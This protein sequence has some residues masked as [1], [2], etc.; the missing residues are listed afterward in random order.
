MAVFKPLNIERDFYNMS[1]SSE[2]SAEITL[3]GDVVEERPWD[4]WNDKPVE[5]NFIALNDFLSDF[6]KFS[7]CKKINFRINSYGGDCVT[8]FVIHN[9]I[10]DLI[11]DGAEVSCVIDG[12]AMSAASIIMAA[13]D[14][15]KVNPAS[16]VMIHKCWS[17]IWGGY[18][19]DD[20]RSMAEQNDAY[21]KAI[22]SAYAR[23]TGLSETVIMH[24][25]GDTTYMT[26]KEAV[27]KGFADELIEDAEPLNLAASADGKSIYVRGK[28]MHLAPGMFAP[29]IIPTIDSEPKDS[30]IDK[31]TNKEPEDTGRTEGGTSPM[32]MDELRTQY[33]D[34]V[35][36]VEADASAGHENAISAAVN[37]E[38]DRIKK[39]DEVASLFSDD[40]VNEAKFGENACTAEQLAYR[41][42]LKARE[43]GNAFLAQVK[44][45][46][47]ESNTEE[48]G[49]AAPTEN[50]PEE[51]MTDEEKQA[52]AE[53]YMAQLLGKKED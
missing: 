36:Q 28:Q 30:A 42:A 8:A 24:M 47:S 5:G 21:D 3:Y 39:I 27:E 10:R 2:E 20:L 25:M 32:T 45:D 9:R 48:V 38:R 52:M 40:L 4:W 46:N 51:A 50:K 43:Q 22:A 17:Y 37:A 23:K 11:R 44:A 13:C 34:L 14:N 1:A 49:S 29:D 12:C 16:L 19:G 15:V 26:G 31:E 7:K 41:A 35:A 53:K 18:N 6:E 33:P